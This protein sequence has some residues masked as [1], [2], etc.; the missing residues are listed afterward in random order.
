MTNDHD[1]CCDFAKNAKNNMEVKHTYQ[2]QFMFYRIWIVL[3]LR[4]VSAVAPPHITTGES[5]NTRCT[6]F[7]Q[8]WSQSWSSISGVGSIV[9]QKVMIIER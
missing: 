8:S 9:G 6:A 2:D 3:I 4:S 7:S 1:V 5:R